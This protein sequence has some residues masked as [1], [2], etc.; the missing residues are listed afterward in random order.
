[1]LLLSGSRKIIRHS[2]P[3]EFTAKILDHTC[4]HSGDGIL[5]CWKGTAIVPTAYLPPNVTR[6]NAYAIHGSGKK[7]AYEALYPVSD[8]IF[9]SPDLCVFYLTILNKGIYFVDINFFFAYTSH[10]LEYFR[11]IDTSQFL[12]EPVTEL[13]PMWVESLHAHA[14]T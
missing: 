6:M 11:P 7:R 4:S 3:L 8:G 9:E 14:V 2:L 5:K 12:S 10:R 1:M 13:S